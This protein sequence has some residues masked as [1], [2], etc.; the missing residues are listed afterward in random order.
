MKD[1]FYIL[2]SHS[3]AIILSCWVGVGGGGVKR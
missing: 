3:S 1:N 2:S